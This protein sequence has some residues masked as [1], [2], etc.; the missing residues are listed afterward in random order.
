MQTKKEVVPDVKFY[1]MPT[2]SH[3]RLWGFTHTSTVGRAKSNESSAVPGEE[4]AN[5][6]RKGHLP[7]GRRASTPIN[8]AT[9]MRWKLHLSHKATGTGM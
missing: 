6:S 8:E 9:L 2:D 1:K 7:Q 3:P 5:Q 4:P